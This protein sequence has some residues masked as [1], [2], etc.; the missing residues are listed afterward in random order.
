MESAERKLAAILA[1]DVVNY[2]SKM[3]AN[4]Q[5]TL[6]QLKECREIIEKVV[7]FHKGRIFNTAGDAFMIE[8]ASPVTAL[9]SA[10]TIQKQISER[11]YK[12]AEDDHLE[13]RIGVNMG[14]I[15]IEEDNLFGEGVNIAARLEGIAPA[16]GICISEMVYSM[17]KGKVQA[18]FND[19]GDQNLKN[20]N[21]PVR[22]YFVEERAAGPKTSSKGKSHSQT[23]FKANWVIAGAML[24][25][26]IAYWVVNSQNENGEEV[27]STTELNTLV[28]V[29]LENLGG[30]SEQETFALGLSQELATGLTRGAKGLNIIGLSSQPANLQETAKKMGATYFLSGSLR[31]SSDTFRVTVKL[32]NADTLGALWTDTY[33]KDKS[34]KNIFEIQDAVVSDVLDELVGNGAIL[35][36][37]LANRVKT[38]GTASLSA[39]ECVT[40]A[41]VVFMR[42]LSLEDYKKS[43]SCLSNAVESDPQYAEAWGR[44]GELKSFGVAFGYDQDSSLINDSI[45]ALDRAIA[46]DPNNALFYAGRAEVY[47]HDQQWQK[48]Y[49]DG[50]KAL[51]LAPNDAFV[52]TGVGYQHL[53][54]GTCTTEQVMDVD[55]EY[56]KYISGNCRWQKGVRYLEKGHRLD[57][58]NLHPGNNY[59]L[60]W[61]YWI[62]GDYDKAL[63]TAQMINQPNWIWW[64]LLIGMSHHG[65]GNTEAAREKFLAA[66]NLIGSNGIDAL[67][68][69]Y[70]HWRVEEYWPLHEKIYKGYNFK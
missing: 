68:P 27:A 14:D 70:T 12:L 34:A 50:E 9:D 38:K 33:D 25:C 46:L 1:M 29:P 63:K 55:A 48:M 11:N 3:S 45:A 53:W 15:M 35:S 13:F 19:Q 16:G 65:L 22:A 61:Y 36:S 47:Y 23:G 24:V 21:E 57:K 44:L 64:H 52:L 31:S 58:A 28:V 66:E 7:S 62:S 10:L 2:S 20:I 32:L 18:S 37:D 42:S 69:L 30:D 41:N 59:G 51:N 26:G 5:G 67:Y 43:I 54:G 49:E 8:F 17:A 39:Y 4:E 40:F 6:R 60:G 56:G